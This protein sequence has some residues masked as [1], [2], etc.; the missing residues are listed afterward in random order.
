MRIVAPLPLPVQGTVTGN[1]GI[2]G[3][4]N[5]NVTN[6]PATQPVSGAVSITGTPTVNIGNFP[7]SSALKPSQLV[8]AFNNIVSPDNNCG[9]GNGNV[10]DTVGN[11]DGTTSPLSIP[12]GKVLVITSATLNS[13]AGIAGHRIFLTIN[14]AAAAGGIPV[15]TQVGLSSST[16][17][18]SAV[19]SFPTGVVVKSGVSVCVSAFDGSAL[20]SGNILAEIQGYITTDE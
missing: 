5:V 18:T 12:S 3:T 4:A 14:R 15:G 6:F 2:T 10:V 1:V 17:D 16:G 9:S 7:A 13:T 20:Q 8:S 11:S 19:F